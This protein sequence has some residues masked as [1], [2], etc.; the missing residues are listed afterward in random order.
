MASEPA[1]NGDPV[2]DLECE[3]ADPDEGVDGGHGGVEE[4]A[5]DGAVDVVDCLDW[6]LAGLLYKRMD[7]A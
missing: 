4:G 6:V 7:R 1:A 3:G 2:H 5:E